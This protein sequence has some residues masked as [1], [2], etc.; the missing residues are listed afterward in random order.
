MKLEIC[1]V[2]FQLIG[3]IALDV[4]SHGTSNRELTK[5]NRDIP[6]IHHLKHALINAI[7]WSWV[8]KLRHHKD[9]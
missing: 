7:S 2:C 8:N 9:A 3:V 5:R 6:N 1:L 4:N